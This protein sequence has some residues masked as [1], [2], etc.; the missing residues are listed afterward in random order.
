[1][2]FENIKTTRYIPME[3]KRLVYMRAEHK[4]ENCGCRRNLQID[5]IVPLAKGGLTEPNNLRL[6]CFECNQRAGIKEFGVG[7]MEKKR[8]IKFHELP[9]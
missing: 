3:M 8:E 5:H 1:L 6:L 9:S 2:E 7:F 4:C